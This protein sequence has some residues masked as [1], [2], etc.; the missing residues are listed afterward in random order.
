MMSSPPSYKDY[1]L[2]FSEKDLEQIKLAGININDVLLQLQYFQTGFP[3]TRIDSTCTIK[4]GIKAFTD[5]EKI[6]F[7]EK[8]NNENKVD[9]VKFVPASG[10]ASRMFKHL[11]SLLI[12]KKNAAISP[13]DF[14]LSEDF[15]VNFKKFAFW[16]KLSKSLAAKGKNAESLFDS[17][18]FG[19]LIKELLENEGLNYSNQPKGLVGFHG[20]KNGEIRNAFEEHIFESLDYIFKNECIKMHFTVAEESKTE[21][22][23]LIDSYIDRIKKMHNKTV[24]VVLTVQKKSTDTI[25]VD[26]DNNLLRDNNGNLVFR[27]AGHGALI[28]NLNEMDA[29]LVFIKNIDNITIDS[30]K[31]PTVE[32]KKLLA[33][34]L[35]SIKEKVFEYLLLLENRVDENKLKEIKEF[36]FRELH[37]S[38]NDVSSREDITKHLNK[39]IR[40]CGMVRNQGEPGGGP[41]WTIDGEGKKSLQVVET[42]QIDNQDVEQM[43]LLKKATHFNPVDLVCLLKNYQGKKFDLLNFRDMNTGFISKKSVNGKD[44]KALELPGLWNGAMAHWITLFIEVPIETFNPVKTVNDLLRPA[45]Q[46]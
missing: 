6:D 9:V 12:D 20:Y 16:S 32:Y 17:Q 24:E 19:V 13:N 41:F 18:Q 3:F 1:K 4:S 10:A 29:E 14:K 42:S 26:L 46:P 43:N 7:S 36:A 5:Q 34:Y 11:H 33:G 8:Y 39:P 35:L 15:L 23:K 40:V 30:L 27:P 25:A 22:Q 31:Q 45:H 28:E 44:C 38:L 2:L 21:I 37:I